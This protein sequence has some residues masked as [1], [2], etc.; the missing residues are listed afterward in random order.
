MAGA[1]LGDILI[2]LRQDREIV[3]MT[4]IKAADTPQWL[5]AA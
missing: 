1:L 4:A 3:V 5:R 2:S